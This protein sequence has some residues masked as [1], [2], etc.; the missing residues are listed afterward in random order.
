MQNQIRVHNYAKATAP[1]LP[2]WGKNAVIYAVNLRQFTAEGTIQAFKRHLPRLQSLGVTVLWFLPIHPIGRKN[3]KGRLGSYYSIQDYYDINPEFGTRDDFQDLVR[4]IH[5]MGLYVIIDL[6]INHTAWDNPLI[7]EHPEW[8]THDEKGQIVAPFSGWQDVADLDYSNRTLR[9]YMTEMMCHWVGD[10]GVDGFRC[11]VAELVPNDFW[12]DATGELQKL[13]SV[14]LLAEGQHPSLH[15]H[16][17]HIS[18]AF[19]MYWLMN[20]IVHS[21]RRLFEIDRKKYA[22][23]A[24]RLRYT[25]N[26]DENSWHGSAVERLG[27]AAKAMAV[28]TFTLPGTPLIYNGQEVGNTKRLDFFEKDEIKWQKSSFEA[29]YTILCRL[30]KD[31]PA[32]Y[33][34]EMQRIKSGNPE[35]IYAFKRQK[36]NDHIIV[37]LNLSGKAV[38]TTLRM[39]VDTEYED[40]FTGKSLKRSSANPKLALGSWG[41]RIYVPLNGTRI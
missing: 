4:S 16:G 28:L 27:H 33:S 39:N 20:D 22:K 3:R 12:R 26:H 21:K 7:E 35:S 13:K 6:V 23:G 11:D 15:A 25:S 1:R 5:N 17:F 9:H 36:K 10:V 30:Y 18:Y 31:R 8:Y 29:F 24:R 37:I 32:L 34:G 2:E 19:N 40:I 38:E 14:L 41:Y